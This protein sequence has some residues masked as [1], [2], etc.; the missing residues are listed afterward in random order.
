DI[1]TRP[2]R[3]VAIIFLFSAIAIS[4]AL[5]LLFKYYARTAVAP[6]RELVDSQ[7]R[8]SAPTAPEPRIQGVPTFHG[9]VPRADMEQLRRESQQRLNSYGKA[10]D[11]GFVRIPIDRAMQILSEKGMSP[12]TRK[13]R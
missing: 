11:Q 3:I 5:L 12:T 1:N 7:V 2:L 4:L 10:E 8:K 13:A 9:N 6:D